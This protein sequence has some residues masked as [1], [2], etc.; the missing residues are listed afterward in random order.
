MTK[1]VNLIGGPGIGKSV[2]A[3]ELFVKMKKNHLNCEL[4]YEYPKEM[5][6]EENQKLLENQIV[7][8][9]GQ[10]RKVWS[11]NGKVDYIITDSPLIM[12]SVYFEYYLEKTK[13][14]FSSEY[15]QLSI[16]FFD[17]TFLE[18]DNINFVLSRQ[19]DYQEQ[20]RNQKEDEARNLDSTLVKKLIDRKIPYFSVP[21]YLDDEQ[22]VN[23]IYNNIITE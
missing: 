19:F 20:G 5:T 7:T 22:R 17:Q 8:F 1:V 15:K 18:F 4:I 14:Q 2:L 11:L 13:K 12:Y 6:W 23:L 10:H 3:A 9:A 21:K 16:D